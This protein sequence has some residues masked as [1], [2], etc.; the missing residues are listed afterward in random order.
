MISTVT[1]KHELTFSSSS[2][3][4]FPHTPPLHHPSPPL[5]SHLPTTQGIQLRREE[6]MRLFK[7]V[8]TNGDRSVS[9][10]ELKS[11][12]YGKRYPHPR[13]VPPPTPAVAQRPYMA[14]TLSAKWI[15]SACTVLNRPHV[16]TC[17]T[18]GTPHPKGDAWDDFK[19]SQRRSAK[20]AAKAKDANGGGGK[21]AGAAS[22]RRR[23]RRQEREEREERD[24]RRGAA[25]TAM[26]GGSRMYPPVSLIETRRKAEDAINTSMTR[27]RTLLKLMDQVRLWK[28]CRGGIVMF[29]GCCVVLMVYVHV[30]SI[31]YTRCYPF[32]PNQLYTGG[33]S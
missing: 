6:V 25:A 19:A 2:H 1:H 9:L 23:N 27:Q 4:P 32:L 33:C 15:C 30:V 7:A 14:P 10:Q 29:V 21:H 17:A 18:C 24:G 28:A 8:D 3:P 20:D 13:L 22:E 11:T 16:L 5:P 26:S 31:A 12:V